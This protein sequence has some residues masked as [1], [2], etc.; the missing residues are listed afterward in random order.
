MMLMDGY[1]R[2]WFVASLAPHLQMTLSQEKILTLAKALEIAM[3][4]HE[5]PI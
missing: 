5:T 4:F 1:H 3:R 2:T